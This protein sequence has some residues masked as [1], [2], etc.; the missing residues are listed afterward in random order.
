MTRSSSTPDDVVPSQISH[1]AKER[2]LRIE[3]FR[4]CFV[5]LDGELKLAIN[6]YAVACSWEKPVGQHFGDARVSAQIV[7]RQ[8][9]PK[10]QQSP[11]SN[12]R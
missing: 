2:S 6:P 5:R 9:A 4:N 11:A 3:V 1:R 12:S 8:L 10:H 7:E